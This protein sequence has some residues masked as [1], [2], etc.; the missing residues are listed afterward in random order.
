MKKRTILSI[1]TSLVLLVVTYFVVYAAF[2]VNGPY[3]G[4][5]GYHEINNALCGNKNRCVPKSV[6]VIEMN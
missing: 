1:L 6:V 2:T 4:D 3:A 5:I